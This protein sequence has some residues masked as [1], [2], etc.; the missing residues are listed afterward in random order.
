MVAGE[1]VYDLSIK[2]HNTIS[3]EAQF[4]GMKVTHLLRL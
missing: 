3:D 4:R 1:Q 2:L